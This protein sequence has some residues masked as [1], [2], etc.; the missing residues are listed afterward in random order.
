MLTALVM[1]LALLFEKMLNLGFLLLL[2]L[3]PLF[4]DT[5]DS[6]KFGFLYSICFHSPA[7]QRRNTILFRDINLSCSPLDPLAPVAHLNSP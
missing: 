5:S 3:H 7:E 1:S 4:V 6:V 2:F